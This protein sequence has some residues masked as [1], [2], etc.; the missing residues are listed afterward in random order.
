MK[1]KT[2]LSAAFLISLLPMLLNQYGGMKGVQEIP[3]LINLL[4]PIGIAAV[5]SFTVGVWASFPKQAVGKIL[6]AAGVTGIVISEL[7]QFF[8]WHVLTITG[9]VSLQNSLRF[10]FPEFY[11]GL[12]VSLVMV[13]VYFVIDARWPQNALPKTQ[14]ESDFPCEPKT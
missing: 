2:A 7:Y 10:A 13:A 14:P 12:T 3:G 4:N 1:K 11:L 6:G 8:T 5:I 9:E